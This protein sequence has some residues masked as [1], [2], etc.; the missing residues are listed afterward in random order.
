LAASEIA[1]GVMATAVAYLLGSIPSAYLLPPLLTGADTPRKGGG[2]G[3]LNVYRELGMRS[4]IAVV[5]ADMAKGAAAVSIAHWLLGLPQLFVLIV[6][7]AAVAGH[8]WMVFLRFHG[9]GGI[10]TS[11]GVLITLMPIYGYW[12]ELLIFISIMAIVVAIARNATASAVVAQLFL[13]LVVWLGTHSLPVTIFSIALG[14]IM[15]L[16]RLPTLGRDWAQ[17]GSMKHFI[18]H[19]SF[20]RNRR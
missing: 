13:P 18:F 16:K 8:L 17:A 6:G 19:N 3:G 9:G 15:G 12:P 14:L 7:V 5:A 4:G 10:A 2:V 11:V 1:M 20:R